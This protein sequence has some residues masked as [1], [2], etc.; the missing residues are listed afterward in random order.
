MK[1]T[2][3]LIDITSNITQNQQEIEALLA[4]AQAVL[5]QTSFEVAARTIF[6]TCKTVIGATAGYVALLSEDGDRNE[7]L[8]LDAGGLPGSGDPALPRRRRGLRAE[9][10]RLGQ[11][12]FDNDFTQS[13]WWSF[14]PADQV[15]LANVLCAPFMIDGRAVGLLGLANK[16]GGFTKHDADLAKKFAEFAA[17]AF[18]QT[19]GKEA[20]SESESRFRQ[21]FELAADAH[22]LHDMGTIIEV[23]QQACQSLGYTREELL[24]MQ[25]SDIEVGRGPEELA[26]I[27]QEDTH[28]TISFIGIRRRKD[29]STFPVEV[30]SSRFSFGGRILR[31]AAARDITQRQRQERELKENENRFR[32]LFNHMKSGVAI[33]EVRHNGEEV[34]FKDINQGA[35]R[36]E[37]L[38]REDLLGKDVREIFP[39]IEDYDL[40]EAIRRVWWT[41]QSE[42]LPE[43]FYQYGQSSGWRDHFV[44]KLPSDEVV[45]IYDNVTVRVLAEKAL[46]EGEERLRQLAEHIQAAFWIATPDI[47]EMIYVSPAYEKIWGRSCES[48]YKSPKS[49]FDAIHPEDRDRVANV[50]DKNRFQ[51][52][53]WTI[54]YRIIRPDGSTCWVEDQGFPVHDGTGH[55]PRFIGVTTDITNRKRVED[56]LKAAKAQLEYLLTASPAV[57]YSCEAAPPFRFTFVSE[58]VASL[59]GYES[60]KFMDN[61]ALWQAHIHPEDIFGVSTAITILFE[62]GQISLEYRFRRQ[63]GTYLW[64]QDEMILVNDDQG[65]PM[66]IVGFLINISKRKRAEEALRQSEIQYRS[67]VENTLDG[68]AIYQ[69]PAGH[70]LFLNQRMCELYGCSRPEGLRLSFRDLIV[71]QDQDRFLNWVQAHLQGDNHASAPQDFTMRRKDASSFLAEVAVSLISYQGNPAIQVVVR[72]VSERE[73]LRQQVQHA[74]KMQALGTMAAGIAHE[75][76]SPLTV[77]SSAA[78]FIMEDDLTPEFR[79]QCLE[80]MLSGITKASSIIENLLKF[81]RSPEKVEAARMELRT[82]I[83]DTLALVT[84]Q[85]K[86]QN[87][88]I[89]KVMPGAPVYF[90]GFAGL[91]PQA[92]MNLFIN[93]VNAMPDGGI[94]SVRLELTD[95]ETVVIITDSGHGIAPSDLPLIFD[96]FFSN[97]Q[98]GQGTGL[99]LSIC[100][101][102]IRQHL[103]SIEVESTLGKGTKFIV[104]LPL[105][106]PG[107][108]PARVSPDPF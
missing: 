95:Q 22:W 88:S 41:G 12:G 1:T 91:L 52:T 51:K 69:F 74:Q 108:P 98:V 39:G 60:C 29:G 76:R 9:D 62:C 65:T 68:Y 46:R 40:F 6:E 67:L 30:R 13:D 79:H 38:N 89:E 20:L 19:R 75:I 15:H 56:D 100:Q 4:G 63:D 54:T 49:F 85:A 106:L 26:K 2:L 35:E 81:A 10:F 84:N 47:D 59:L 14:F 83:N 55:V 3:P 104:R 99:G 16:P 17:I 28:A 86:L 44:Y 25:V 107:M 58:N 61:P 90:Y 33:Y 103:G 24:Q 8:C 70:F 87:V 48:L 71:P 73:R 53:P 96:P 57:I 82:V 36:L 34:V 77:C 23:N 93:A 66:E 92:F 31:L 32:E 80:K 50:L 105:I 78:Q 27:W 11:P 21:L 72:D 18:R 64:I 42:H 7:L 45:V 101:S 43:A 5:S 97:S 94:L 37:G 102:I